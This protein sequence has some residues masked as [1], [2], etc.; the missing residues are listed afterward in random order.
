MTQLHLQPIEGS[1]A[2]R[3]NVFASHARISGSTIARSCGV[4]AAPMSSGGA[5]VSRR[6]DPARDR[7]EHAARRL[8]DGS[9]ARGCCPS[10]PT[11]LMAAWEAEAERRGSV[12]RRALRRR[13]RVGLDRG[14]AAATQPRDR[15]KTLK[16]AAARRDRR[17]HD[18]R[19]GDRRVPGPNGCAH[20]G[21]L[22]DRRRAGA[23][24]GGD[25]RGLGAPGGRSGISDSFGDERRFASTAAMMAGRGCGRW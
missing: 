17:P 3:R 11:R 2:S 18:R 25:D 12:R 5:P 9:W 1:T 6:P 8:A 15:P 14:S 13:D 16:A 22:G 24:G 4:P 7:F 19:L 10:A 20:D 21:S 23:D